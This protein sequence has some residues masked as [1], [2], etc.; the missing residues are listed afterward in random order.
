MP[1][2]AYAAVYAY[3]LAAGWGAAASYAL[4]AAAYIGTTIAISYAANEIL[5]PSAN[6][7]G[8]QQNRGLGQSFSN[9]QGVIGGAA[10]SNTIRQSAAPRRLIYGTVK[11]GGVLVYAKKTPNERFLHL[12]N[13][14][15]EGPIESVSNTVYLGDRLSSEADFAGLLTRTVYTGAPGQGHSAALAA[16][17][18][19]EWTSDMVGNG[20]AWVHTVYT[21]EAES[22]RIGPVMPAFLVSGRRVH[23]PR[24]NATAHTSNPALVMLDFIRSEFG[25][26]APDAWIDFDS[27]AVAAS[28]CDEVITSLDTSNVVDGVPGRVRRYSLNGV[29]EVDASPAATVDAIEQTCAGKLVFSGGKYRFYVGAYRAAT[30]PQL[31]AE[32]L[33][34]DPMFRA[35]PSRQQRYNIARGTYRE[36][37]QDWQD[38]D[39]FE[40]VLSAA[41]VAEDGEIVQSLTLPAVTNGAQ[42]Q[43]LARIRMMTARSATPLILRCNYAVFQWRLYDVVSLSLPEVGAVG[44]FL[45]VGYSFADLEEGGGIDLTL[46]PH[47]A[48]DYAWDAATMEQLVPTVA[49]PNFSYPAPTVTGLL[50]TSSTLF[51]NGSDQVDRFMTANWDEPDWA[52]TNYYEVQIKKDADDWVSHQVSETKYRAAVS[53]DSAY[54]VRV[55]VVGLNGKKGPWSTEQTLAVFRDTSAPGAPTNYSVGGNYGHEVRWTAPTS[56]NYALMRVYTVA[57]AGLGGSTQVAAVPGRP[58]SRGSV[59]MARPPGTHYAIAPESVDGVVGALVYVGQG[60]TD[61]GTYIQPELDALDDRITAIETGP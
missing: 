27:F 39:L 50:L 21:F 41:V 37:K 59:T 45:I 43:R 56:S 55:R 8:N 40:Q 11:T 26:A 48:S 2:A 28:V 13:Y 14:I 22:W 10:L 60:L 16:V 9:A 18:E 49:R 19:G 42:A 52:I 17:S 58:G 31:N 33:R 32:Y 4:G 5:A 23:D 34:A 36:P 24:T 44:D 1:Q 7:V 53:P 57:D 3:G 35:H 46:V 12:A 15:G 47:L 54:A 6:K 29:F 61:P 30:G 25:Y 20:C 38:I 51:Y